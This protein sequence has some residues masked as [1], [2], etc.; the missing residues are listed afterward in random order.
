MSNSKPFKE[1]GD[2]DDS[3]DDNEDYL[4]KLIL[5]LTDEEEK[6]ES[7]LKKLKL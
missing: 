6:A 2:N 7:E 3:T 5:K 4:K 1:L